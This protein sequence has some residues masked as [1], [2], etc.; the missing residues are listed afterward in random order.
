MRA[1]TDDTLTIRPQRVPIMGSSSGCVA[2][3][4]PLTD[5][6]ITLCHCVALMPGS[7]ASSCTP[8]LLTRIWMGPCSSTASSEARVA[9]PS[10]RS[11]LTSVASPP[12]A[13]I[14]PTSA[15]AT[16]TP[17][18]EC[19]YTWCPSRASRRH[20]AP[21]IAPLPPVTRARRPVPLVARGALMRGFRWRAAEAGVEHDAGAPAEELQP[22]AR[23]REFVEHRAAVAGEALGGGDQIGL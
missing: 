9:A 2:L 18:C 20:T 15:S 3:K 8:A 6:S 4:K 17:R 10:V 21:P 19:T 14:S 7:T 12:P 23:H 5:T 16:V 1:A 11:Q 13:R 22:P